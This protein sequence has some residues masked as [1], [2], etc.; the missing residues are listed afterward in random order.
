MSEIIEEDANV[1]PPRFVQYNAARVRDA[2][3][4]TSLV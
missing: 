4:L 2:P 1:R 3:I